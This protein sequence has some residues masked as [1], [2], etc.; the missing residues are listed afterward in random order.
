[1]SVLDLKSERHAMLLPHRVSATL[2]VSYPDQKLADSYETK[3]REK[4]GKSG[5]KWELDRVAER[6]PMKDRSINRRLYKALA[7]SAEQQDTI[8]VEGREGWLFF[9]P[10]LR[11][12]G[13]GKFWGDA[14]RAVNPSMSELGN[15][16]G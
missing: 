6:P 10:E 8:V 16:H 14:A 12:L 9:G 7:Q 2:L 15:G 5:P 3:L 11:H 13:V 4:L 1:M